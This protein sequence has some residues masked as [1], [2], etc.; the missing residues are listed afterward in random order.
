MDGNV[1][2]MRNRFSSQAY[3]QAALAP[4]RWLALRE[5]VE[6]DPDEEQLARVAGE[7]VPLLVGLLRRAG[8][9][10]RTPES[11]PQ[12]ARECV[13][14]LG[15]NAAR[16]QLHALLQLIPARLDAAL[17]DRVAACR[18]AGDQLLSQL[19][20]EELPIQPVDRTL[21]LLLQWIPFLVRLQGGEEP[22]LDQLGQWLLE[23]IGGRGTLHPQ[24]TEALEACASPDT[25]PDPAGRR[26]ALLR[27]AWQLAGMERSSLRVEPA[28]IS[29]LGLRA[30]GHAAGSPR[31]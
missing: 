16:L 20:N 17:E 13:T 19:A 30:S 12:D 18:S 8:A 24:L 10:S 11:R 22:T 9:T 3:L 1:V 14:R 2:G 7:H 6:T 15:R 26:G 4:A 28:L 23:G 21:L 25:H 27:A 5:L 29:R 31:G